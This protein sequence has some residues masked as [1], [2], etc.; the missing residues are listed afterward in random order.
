MSLLSELQRDFCDALLSSE[1]PFPA[2]L[3]E[4]ADDRLALQRFQVYRNN[5]IILN[6][7]AIADMYPV[8]KRLVGDE[9]FRMLATAYVRNHPPMERTLL[10]YGALFA[11]FL[12]T[13]PE[14]S[15]LAYLSDVARLEFAW[16]A[17]YHATDE[18]PLMAE[19]IARLSSD[20]IADLHLQPHNSLQ[21]LASDY[22][23]HRIWMVNQN[24]PQDVVISLD[25][26]PSRLAVI[27]PQSEVEVRELSIGEFELLRC[28]V[29]GKPVGQAFESAVSLETNFDLQPFF[30]R[31][32]LDGTFTEKIVIPGA[33]E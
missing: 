24:D 29:D 15:G 5:F 28:L 32:L 25:E 7:D 3:S 31:H 17:A 23:I 1:Q 26:G 22:P 10:L 6:G 30:A 33:T 12:A 21:L 8:V 18:R 16:T 4:I 9:A 20:D 19:Q 13:I 11:D 27:R 2:L 14:L